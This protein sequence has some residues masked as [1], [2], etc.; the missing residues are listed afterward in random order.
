MKL[1]SARTRRPSSIWPKVGCSKDRVKWTCGMPNGSGLRSS[2]VAVSVTLS[3]RRRQKRL[4]GWMSAAAFPRP[5]MLKKY[6]G[7]AA[8]R[9]GV[10]STTTPYSPKVNQKQKNT[11]FRQEFACICDDFSRIPGLGSALGQ[12]R[13][14]ARRG[15]APLARIGLVIVFDFGK[16]VEVVDHHPRRLLKPLGREVGAPI[17]PLHARPVGQMEMGDGVENAPLGRLLVEQILRGQAQQRAAQ[18]RRQELVRLP[19]RLRQKLAEARRGELPR[20][21]LLQRLALVDG[22]EIVP[23]A[24]P[25]VE[26]AAEARD[27]RERGEG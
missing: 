24:K 6:I 27:G 26:P 17:E 10:H 12:T 5:H 16:P 21:P 4:P 14:G 11:P 18:R 19:I 23:G 8:L 1:R 7:V 22:E 13:H 2:T 3:R 25:R 20:E 15:D 9:A